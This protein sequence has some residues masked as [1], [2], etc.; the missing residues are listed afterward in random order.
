MF[1]DSGM[2]PRYNSRDSPWWFLQSIQDYTLATSST[3]ILSKTLLRRF[4]LDDTWIPHTSPD[5]YTHTSTLEEVIQEIMQRH[6][7]GIRF[8]EYN[9][10]D[11]L[12]SQ[13]KNEGFEID[14]KVDWNTGF[15]EGGNEFNCGTWM[16]RS[17]FSFS[18][19]SCPIDES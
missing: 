7:N 18:P 11:G 16:V 9:A 10:G 8:R 14:I 19:S 4:P 2:T 5:A 12:D 6:A 13:M 3:S 1:Q 15:I 17:L